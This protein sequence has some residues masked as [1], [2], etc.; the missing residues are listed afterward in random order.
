MLTKNKFNRAANLLVCLVFVFFCVQIASAQNDKTL[1]AW[2]SYK[3]ITIGMTTA[4]VKQKL[5]GAKSETA[6]DWSYK[7]SD[8]ETAEI[9]LDAAKKVRAVTVMFSED[10]L[11]AP[12]FE[13]VFGKTA[14]AE[15]KPDG[16]V[17]KL[18]RFTDAGYWLS[19][20]RQAGDKA[21]VIVMIQKL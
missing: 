6:D 1:P 3:G 4:E 12:K 7:F 15:P 20:S 21:M 8:T 2:Q 10:H 16:S 17:Y 13:E 18:I 14:K 9:I 19:Y 5:G 11:N